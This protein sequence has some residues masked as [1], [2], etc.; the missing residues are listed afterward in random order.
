[1]G[2]RETGG[3]VECLVLQPI[4]KNQAHCLIRSGAKK[5]GLT[6]RI[7]DWASAKV[8]SLAED[9]AGVFLVEFSFERVSGIDEL[10]EKAGS[11]PLPPYIHRKADL[12]DQERYQTIYARAKGSVAAPT[13]GLHFTPSL[14]AKIRE[15]GVEIAFVTLQV[16]IGTFRPITADKVEDHVM[17]EEPYIV[18]QDTIQKIKQTKSNGGRVIAV[19]TTSV[20]SLEAMAREINGHFP[21]D[22][23]ESKTN[24]FIKPGSNF[25]LVDCMITNFHQPK[26]SLIVMV[27]AFAGTDKIKFAYQEAI[28][29][30]YRFN[31][32][33]DAMFI[34]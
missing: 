34:R 23:F 24:L 18:P 27:S 1:M 2:K 13:A 29:K 6:F 30:R 33:G 15:L 19:G 8:I 17:H 20:R 11:L 14:L 5:A 26:S 3:E 22:N 12:L 25:L 4:G 28:Q 9:I 21:V 32:Y 31:S 7:Q 16:G 10:L